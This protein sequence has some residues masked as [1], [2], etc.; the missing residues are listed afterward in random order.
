ML[1]FLFSIFLL[2][3]F[4]ILV[5]NWWATLAYLNERTHL[6]IVFIIEI[7][8]FA[9]C[10]FSISFFFF[11][12]SWNV[13]DV[14]RV[15]GIKVCVWLNFISKFEFSPRD[16]NKNFSNYFCFRPTYHFKIDE[17]IVIIKGC[18]CSRFFT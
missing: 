11:Y 1:S 13:F 14:W 8:R 17:V 9:D 15:V 5:K 18:F 12:F 10:L 7:F 16:F 3:Y 6:L 4:I 2:W